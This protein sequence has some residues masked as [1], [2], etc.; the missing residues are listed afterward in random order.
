MGRVGPP[1]SGH[2]AKMVHN[3]IEYG[4]MQAYA[5]GFS[6]LQHEEDFSSTCTRSPRSGGTV[7]WCV[8]GCSIWADALAKNQLDGIAPYVPDSGEGRWTVAEA[9]DLDVPA[10][11]ITLSLLERCA[12]ASGVVLRQAVGGAAQR[13]RWTRDQKR[14]SH[15]WAD[16][17]RVSPAPQIRCTSPA[18][19]PD[20]C[21]EA[22][23]CSVS[24]APH[25][26]PSRS[27]GGFFSFWRA[28]STPGIGVYD[29]VA[30]GAH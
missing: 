4:L 2:F 11:V 20:P 1:G 21:S 7:A 27:V 29:H 8:R 19:S 12:R 30:C 24:S 10:P 3:G 18:I 25:R 28:A 15:P 23:P 16:V 9:I 14:M 6:I 22:R 26:A 13:V 5:E 17:G